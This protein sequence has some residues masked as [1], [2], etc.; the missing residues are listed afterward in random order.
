MWKDLKRHALDQAGNASV[1]TEVY[2]VEHCGTDIETTFANS[3]PAVIVLP[4]DII[5]SCTLNLLTS[6]LENQDEH[7]LRSLFNTESRA[8]LRYSGSIDR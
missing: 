6:P 1:F 2:F 5:C 7:V 8:C 4:G 3:R